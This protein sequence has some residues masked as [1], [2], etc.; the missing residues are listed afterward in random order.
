MEVR[1]LVSGTSKSIKKVYGG[2]DGGGLYGR[3][4]GT[5]PN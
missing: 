1:L 2:G 5:L 4:D 3:I